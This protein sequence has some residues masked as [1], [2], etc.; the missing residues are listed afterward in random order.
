MILHA[1]QPYLEIL[2]G[3]VYPERLCYQPILRSIK[4]STL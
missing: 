3:D 4:I 2:Q 1:Q